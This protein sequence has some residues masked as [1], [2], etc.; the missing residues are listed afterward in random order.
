ML[1]LK[2]IYIRDPFVL[3]DGGKYYLY[4]TT[5]AQIWKGRADGFKAY[6]SEDLENFEEYV[7]FENSDDFWA[8]EQFWAPE[9]YKYNGKYYL[10]AAFSKGDNVR[11]CQILS[12]DS[13]LGPFVP[14]GG[15]LFPNETS[16]LDATFFVE[17]GKRYT[18]FCR[19]WTDIKVGEI[20]LAELDED[21][22][23]VG[24]IKTLFKAN[25]APWVF[26]IGPGLYYTDGPFIRKNS[27]GQ[28]VMLWSSNG[29][30]GYAMGMAI[31]DKLDGEWK[32]I[33]EP[34]ISPKG[35]HGMIF[36]DRGKLF[37]TYHMPN[38]PHMLE[39]AHFAEIEEDENGAFRLKNNG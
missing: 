26:D 4:G 2:D 19:E 30:D 1:K 15:L 5:D 13:P 36:E 14:Y 10:F 21:L 25:D 29:K 39:R 17:N 6:V 24:E 12:S 38:N 9:V 22:K 32:H 34:L 8:N 20:C 23:V 37:V 11:R 27:K 33:E 18:V 31:A 28:Y 7:I 35:G 3:V 16:N